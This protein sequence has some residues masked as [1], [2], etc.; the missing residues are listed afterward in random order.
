MCEVNW[1]TSQRSVQPIRNRLNRGLCA[2]TY[3]TIIITVS[4]RLLSYL[5]AEARD[6][7][8]GAYISDAC[9]CCS[10]NHNALGQMANQSRLHLLEGGAL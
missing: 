7:G 10:A 8:K 5:K 2:N 4:V 6:Y 9:L 1:V 3:D